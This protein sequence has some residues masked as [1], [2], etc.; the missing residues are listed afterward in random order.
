MAQQADA[1]TS[2]ALIGF[3]LSFGGLVVLLVRKRWFEAIAA[4]LVTASF[5]THFQLSYLLAKQDI[6]DVSFQRDCSI[7]CA[8]DARCSARLGEWPANSSPACR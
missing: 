1:L 8:A 2:P 3:V 5:L 4:G 7:P 6:P